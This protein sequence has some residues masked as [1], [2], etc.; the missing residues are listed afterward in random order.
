MAATASAFELVRTVG[1]TLPEVEVSVKYDGS[2]VL[3]LR[4]CFLAGIAT[5]PSA[6]PDTLVVRATREDR[7]GLIEDAPSTYYVTG[8]YRKHPVVLVR[9]T[10][11]GHDALRELL[12]M[13]WRLTSAKTSARRRPHQT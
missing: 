8:Y 13:S 1:L 5:H 11:I 4:G 6:E 9:L 3:K 2:P 7:Q 12:T 10:E